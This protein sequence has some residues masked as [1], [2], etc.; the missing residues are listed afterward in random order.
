MEGP[1]PRSWSGPVHRS[2]AVLKTGPLSTKDCGCFAIYFAKRFL[3][4]TLAIIK[5]IF[6][7]F[8]NLFDQY[9]I[10]QKPLY[11]PE[12]KLE[13]WGLENADLTFIRQSLKSL[14][15][16]YIARNLAVIEYH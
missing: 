15:F 16:D 5:V 8:S 13:A 3:D 4:E 1:G 9:Y 6:S 7:T 12:E 10:S 11:S 2:Y 14:L